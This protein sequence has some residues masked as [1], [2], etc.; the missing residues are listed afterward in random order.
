VNRVSYK[1]TDASGFRVGIQGNLTDSEIETLAADPKIRTLQFGEPLDPGVWPR[2]D[3]RFFRIRPDVALRAFGHYGKVCD[4]SFLRHV[5]SLQRLV[6]DC[7]RNAE[8]VEA[9]GTL[10][11]LRELS[12][13]IYE[14]PDFTFLT[15]V[16]A[17]LVGLALGE[18]RRSSLSLEPLPRFVGLRR[19]SISGHR[20]SL[21]SIASLPLLESL[22]LSGMK[23]PELGFLASLTKLRRLEMFLGGSEDL[24]AIADATALEHL[25][26]CWIRRLADLGFIS[27][28]KAL[29]FLSLEKLKQ[30][31]QLPDFSGLTRLRGLSLDTMKGLSDVS[32]IAKAPALEWIRYTSAGNLNPSDFERVVAIPSLKGIGVWFGSDR[33][34][35]EFRTL[36]GNRNCEGVDL[37]PEELSR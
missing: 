21:E 9:I 5:P 27:R 16:P 35:L 31:R 25:G 36:A 30:V 11:S 7:L 1:A 3:R 26:L 12:V 8:S 14:L 13:G 10:N 29:Q 23:S 34:N 6:A 18:T 15:Q 20:K 24:S 19:L 28:M 4:L 37:I 2:L 17:G 33:K 32:A 22:V